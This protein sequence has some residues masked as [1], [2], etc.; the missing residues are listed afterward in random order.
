[1]VNMSKTCALIY[2]LFIAFSFS[3]AILMPHIFYFEPEV[4]FV[5]WIL[6]LLYN[7]WKFFDLM[8]LFC[9]GRRHQRT[10]GRIIKP[11]Q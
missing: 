1:M 3:C 5:S 2:H 4:T 11:S 6:Y 7:T 9:A 8:M 10:Q